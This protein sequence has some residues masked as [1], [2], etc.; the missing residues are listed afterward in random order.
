MNKLPRQIAI[1]GA[2]LGTGMSMAM[3]TALAR[4]REL[5]TEVVMLDSAEQLR[6]MVELSPPP[7]HDELMRELRCVPEV[8]EDRKAHKAMMKKANKKKPARGGGRP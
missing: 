5:G 6:D 1:V 2:G 7:R 3:V 4:A 8:A